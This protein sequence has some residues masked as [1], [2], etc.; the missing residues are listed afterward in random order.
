MS[1]VGVGQVFCDQLVLTPLGVSSWVSVKCVRSVDS[2]ANTCHHL[3][4]RRMCANSSFS[5][6][7]V[8]PVGSQASVWDQLELSRVGSQ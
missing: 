2:R 3:I 8:R 4:L 1:P 6:D 7:C 5:G